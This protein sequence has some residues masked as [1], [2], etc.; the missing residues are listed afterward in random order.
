MTIEDGIVQGKMSRRA[1]EM[2]FEWSRRHQAEL[3]KN[4]D[5]A[6]NRRP[7]EPISPLD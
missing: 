4:W 7:L 5:L 2:I 1:L 6:R 3:M